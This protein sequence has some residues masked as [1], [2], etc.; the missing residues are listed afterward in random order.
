MQPVFLAWIEEKGQELF[1]LA[2]DFAQQGIVIY[3]HFC[4]KRNVV[5]SCYEYFWKE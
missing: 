5:E 1:R 4:S 2:L 3:Y